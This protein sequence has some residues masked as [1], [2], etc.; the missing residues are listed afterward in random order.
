VA[1]TPRARQRTTL[2]S[3]LDYAL[4]APASHNTQPWRFEIDEPSR[5]RL[6]ADRTRA[7]PV[8]DPGDRELT[9]SCGAALET[10]VLAAREF[11]F[12]VDVQ[13]CPEPADA[14][15]LATLTLTGER[16]PT[17][18]EGA[19]F[20]A[21]ADRHTQRGAFTAR[22]V[23]PSL[24][25]RLERAAASEPGAWLVTIPEAWRPRVAAL[26]ALGDRRQFRNRRW[27]AELASWL[28][29]GRTGDGLTLDPLPAWIA[30]PVIRSI[31][32]GRRIG[33]SDAALVETAPLVVVLGTERDD[34]ASW[35]A[36]GRAL[37]R[38]LLTAAFHGVQA[39][40]LNQPCQI[41][42]LRR[43][44]RHLVGHEGW[45]QAL[46]RFGHPGRP[47]KASRRRPIEA[48]IAP[49]P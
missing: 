19:R 16:W 7:L 37:Q 12:D 35:L 46:V 26:V 30:R 13:V 2:E 9:M 22:P 11:G 15:L 1:V 39:G 8:N 24:A 40:F 47:A 43:R 27:R 6:F 49:P 38:V 10:L 28:R 14:D 5:I 33:R 41:E 34:R 48:V 3:V 45:P 25:N 23:E 36:A 21:I 42:G 31:D 17:D 29:A 18:E 32:V 4:R 20:V 44:L